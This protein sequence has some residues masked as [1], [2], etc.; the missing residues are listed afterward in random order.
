MQDFVAKKLKWLSNCREHVI[1]FTDMTK[2]QRVLLARRA[3]KHN[4]LA[5]WMRTRHEEN[6]LTH[7]Y[8]NLQA[9]SL[10]QT[11][12]YNLAPIDFN[13]WAIPQ[14]KGRGATKCSNIPATG[15]HNGLELIQNQRE[16][17]LDKIMSQGARTDGLV[18]V[19]EK[20][21]MHKHCKN[22]EG[23]ISLGAS[24]GSQY[25]FSAHY[26]SGLCCD[27][28][29]RLVNLH[30]KEGNSKAQDSSKITEWWAFSQP[31]SSPVHSVSPSASPQFQS[32][33]RYSGNT[34]AL[35]PEFKEDMP[36]QPMRLFG[37]SW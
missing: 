6:D 32:S 15:S 2:L 28:A 11:R 7:L 35:D 24:Q 34:G 10:S 25:A 9:P 4:S 26:L 33:D 3:P 31:P 16:S 5:Q 22:C 20:G 14:P 19:D 29:K 8:H 37:T 36:M 13:N 18:R 17:T 23:W 1:S 12:Y 27:K 30:A 21:I